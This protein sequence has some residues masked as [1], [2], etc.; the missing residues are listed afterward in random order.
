MQKKK[1]GKR[2]LKTDVNIAGVPHTLRYVI[3]S[4]SKLDLTLLAA[5]INNYLHYLTT[6]NFMSHILSYNTSVNQR[7]HSSKF[8]T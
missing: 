3:T 4:R 6:V 1:H 7:T 2:N 8:R 5:D